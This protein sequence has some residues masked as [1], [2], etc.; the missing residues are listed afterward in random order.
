MA[1]PFNYSNDESIRLTAG[2]LSETLKW[3]KQ[4][5]RRMENVTHVP[6]K[7]LNRLNKIFKKIQK[8]QNELY[9]AYVVATASTKPRKV[10]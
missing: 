1:N 7:H 5:H 6:I 4:A 2:C 10:K 3:M 8:Q 9:S